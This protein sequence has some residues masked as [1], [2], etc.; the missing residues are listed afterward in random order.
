MTLRGGAPTPHLHLAAGAILGALVL[1]LAG[2]STPAEPTPKGISCPTA[3]GAEK[4]TT[5]AIPA[6]NPQSSTVPP[7]DAARPARTEVAVFAL[8]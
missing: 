4:E 1:G 7:I 5:M 3:P 2:C 8:G 6:R